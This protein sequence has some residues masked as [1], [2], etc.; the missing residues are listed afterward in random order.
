MMNEVRFNAVNVWAVLCLAT[1]LSGC[2]NMGVDSGTRYYV[3]PKGDDQ[4]PGTRSKPFATLARARD[5][6]R[7]QRSGQTAPPPLARIVLMDGTHVLSEPFILTPQDSDITFDASP[8][9]KPVVSGGVR[10]GGWRKH[11]D[12]LWV[13]DV[14]W[15][16]Q[17]PEPFTQLFVNGVRRT[18]ARTPNEGAYFYTKRL[19]L[20]FDNPGQCLGFSYREPLLIKKRFTI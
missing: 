16:A 5:A 6:V 18:C 15:L 1:M 17:R 12:K 10:I 4:N 8:G 7:G 13:A 3:S 19:S 9:A 2:L 14:P 11:D 20:T